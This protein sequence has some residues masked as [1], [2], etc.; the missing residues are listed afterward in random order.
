[1]AFLTIMLFHSSSLFFIYKRFFEESEQ[2][3]NRK[4]EPAVKEQFR[5]FPF[6]LFNCNQAIWLYCE[7]WLVCQCSV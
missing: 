6:Y 1:M 5:K 2:I 3:K 4:P 7:L